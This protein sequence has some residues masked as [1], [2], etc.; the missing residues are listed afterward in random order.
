MKLK[1]LVLLGAVTCSFFIAVNSSRAQGTAFTY[2]GRLNNA[3]VP[4]SGGYDLSFALFATNAGGVPI[5]GPVTNTAVAVSNG[6]FTTI[7]DFG[8]G[9]FTGDSNWLEIAVRTNGVGVF[10]TLAPRQQITTAPYAI[11]AGSVSG[12]TIQNNS[13]GAP[14]VIAGSP[15]NFA[16]GGAVGATISGGG[17]VNY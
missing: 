17:A 12:V 10:I 7:I 2:Q 15:K 13:D 9:V 14:N 3:G 5:T 11:F 16:Q 8:S 1:N 4:A 6:L